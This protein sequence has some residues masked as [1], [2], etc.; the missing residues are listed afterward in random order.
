MW[1]SI[2]IKYYDRERD[3]YRWKAGE[4]DG[5]TLKSGVRYRL[6]DKAEFEPVE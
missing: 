2:R 1:G 3:V 4:I 5:E 6:N